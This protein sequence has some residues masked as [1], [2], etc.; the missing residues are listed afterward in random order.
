M[1]VKYPPPPPSIEWY[2]ETECGHLLSWSAVDLDSLFIRL[3]EK[4]FRAKEV[5]TWEEHEAKT[6]E[7]ELKESA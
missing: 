7:R 6:S 1:Q 5:M 4:G 2:I 3:H